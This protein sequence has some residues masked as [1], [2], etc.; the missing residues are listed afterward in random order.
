MKRRLLGLVA[1]WI[2]LGVGVHAQD[3]EVFGLSLDQFT[4]EYIHAN[5]VESAR[6]TRK[7]GLGN[8]IY[9]TEAEATS[10]LG[11]RRV[12]SVNRTSATAR[13]E[14]ALP[15][16]SVLQRY[17]SQQTT[18]H[19]RY[20]QVEN[21]GSVIVSALPG[22]LHGRKVLETEDPDILAKLDE[23]QSAANIANS[24]WLSCETGQRA[25]TVCPEGLVSDPNVKQVW[26]MVPFGEYFDALGALRLTVDLNTAIP[27]DEAVAAMRRRYPFLREEQFRA[28]D[29]NWTAFIGDDAVLA[30]TGRRFVIQIAPDRY[31]RAYF[32]SSLRNKRRVI[33]LYEEIQT[34]TKAF[35]DRQTADQ[36]DSIFGGNP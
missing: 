30:T 14:L 16:Y 2:L 15:S 34:M 17:D 24:R 7:V 11:F 21:F 6:R 23:L 31:A 5:E 10:T 27:Y 3:F 20:E 12:V 8:E 1:G 28:E 9:L 36:V 35:Y 18:L 33:D 4:P 25:Y 22:D 13:T 19:N 29:G 26:V 32:N